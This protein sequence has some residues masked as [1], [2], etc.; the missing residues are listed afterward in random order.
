V[1]L[2]CAFNKLTSLAGCHQAKNLTE[3]ACYSND[4]TSLVG[5]PESVTHLYCQENKLTSLDGCPSGILSLGWYDSD[6]MPMI[7]PDLI[8]YAGLTQAQCTAIELFESEK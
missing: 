2:H 3:L 7:G 1:F 6:T 8:R 5:C 4:I